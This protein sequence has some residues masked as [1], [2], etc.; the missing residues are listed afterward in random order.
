LRH[1]SR[2]KTLF[3][4]YQSQLSLNICTS[5]LGSVSS[6]L[7]SLCLMSVRQSL[8]S[9]TGENWPLYQY[10]NNVYW[11]ILCEDEQSQRNGTHYQLVS[12]VCSRSHQKS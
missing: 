10:S 5:C 8:G 1:V 12:R 4:M 11:P 6:F 2:L 3:F 7:V 9:I